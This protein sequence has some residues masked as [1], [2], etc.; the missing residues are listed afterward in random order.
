[1]KLASFG[2]SFLSG[3]ARRQRFVANS[4]VLM[5]SS[6]S[7]APPPET[8][9]TSGAWEVEQK[10]AIPDPNAMMERLAQV[11]FAE[12]KRFEMVDW[13]F[14]VPPTYPLV[15]QDSWLRYRSAANKGDGQWEL[16]R[17]TPRLDDGGKSKATVY[18]EIE[19]GKALTVSQELITA[20]LANRQW[21]EKSSTE[22]DSADLYK[23]YDIPQSPVDIP[24]LSP[25]AR[26]ATQRSTWLPSETDAMENLVVDLDTTD[27]GHAVGEVEMLVGKKSD[28]EGARQDL[29]KWLEDLLGEDTL[30]GPPPMGKLEYFLSTHR[31]SILDVL[32]DAGILPERP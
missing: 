11:G 14:D 7:S 5:S 9:V 16:K 31:P 8:S 26:I 29:Q 24:G 13:Y 19:G 1:M 4:V 15:R 3:F 6:S 12:A 25:I 10:F 23:D 17:G 2:F 32:V 21:D 20:Y 18:E 30:K 28:I 22:N 27:F